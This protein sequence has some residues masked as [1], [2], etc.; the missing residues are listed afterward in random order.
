M[1]GTS[2]RLN[3]RILR[4]YSVRSSLRLL[5]RLSCLVT[6]SALCL[7]MLP[8]VQAASISYGTH[9]GNTVIYED[10][11]ES[12]GTD[13]VPLFGAPIVSGDSIDFNPVLFNAFSQFGSPPVD[14]TNGLLSFVLKAKPGFA[15]NNVTFNEGGLTIVTG[16]GTDNT[17][18]KVSAVGFLNIYEVDHIS[19]GI[20]PVSTQFQM[21]FTHRADGLWELATD[22]LARPEVWT[23]SDFV[24]LDAV[25]TAAGVPFTFGATK[26][27]V[28][29]NNSL[30]ASSESGSTAF[31][32]KK[33][34][35]GLSI[36]VNIPEPSTAILAVACFGLLGLSTR[37]R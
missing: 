29:L 28:V 7:A 33:D 25:L 20:N 32:D 21:T 26:V 37:R 36:T 9:A 11:T 35:G 12:S 3:H 4:S 1:T 14:L 18:T 30:I 24:D 19:T 6:L 22:G 8:S 10:V 16:T 23:G 17:Y 31:I 34:F 15:L 2:L 13:P 5:G 27:S